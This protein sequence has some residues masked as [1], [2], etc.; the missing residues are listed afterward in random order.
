MPAKNTS[1]ATITPPSKRQRRRRPRRTWSHREGSVVATAFWLPRTR[2]CQR[3]LLRPPAST[4][5]PGSCCR[6]LVLTCIM[7]RSQSCGRPCRQDG[8]YSRT[9]GSTTLFFLYFARLPHPS[10]D[11]RIPSCRSSMVILYLCFND[12]RM[13]TAARIGPVDTKAQQAHTKGI[14]SRGSCTST[15]SPLIRT[16]SCS[17]FDLVKAHSKHIPP[18][19]PS[20][21]DLLD[22]PL[23]VCVCWYA[24][25]TATRRERSSLLPSVRNGSQWSQP[26]PALGP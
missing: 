14:G 2:L 11:P 8:R 21:H 13:K 1:S 18:P 10:V 3:Q 6:Q 20:H 26:G 16:Y 19:P 12:A 22:C 15:T 5:N 23:Q 4:R 9:L 25:L 24:Q 7:T 17:R